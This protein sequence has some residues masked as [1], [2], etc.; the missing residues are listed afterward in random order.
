MLKLEIFKNSSQEPQNLCR[1]AA[2]CPPLVNAV[3]KV[4]LLFAFV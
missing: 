1:R 2:V 4:L 3:W